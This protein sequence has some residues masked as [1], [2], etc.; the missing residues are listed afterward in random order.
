MALIYNLVIFFYGL[1]VRIAALFN[2][3]AK[4]FVTGRKHWQ[5]KLKDATGE[6]RNPYIWFHCASLGE[7][8]Q[9][10]PVIEAVKK[11]YPAYKIILTFFSPSGYE[12]RK[13]YEGADIVCYLPLDTKKNANTFL[14]IVQPQ[15]AFFVKYEFWYNYISGLKKRHIPLYIISVIFRKE[16]LFFQNTPGGKWYRKILAGVTHFFVQ[17]EK[18][19]ALLNSI[20]IANY[21]I[22][23][24]TRFDRVAEIAR[25]ARSFEMVERFKG[26]DVTL[27]AG[28]TWKPDEELLIDFINKSSGIKFII[29]PHEVKTANIN[30]ICQALEKNFVLFSKAQHE[31]VEN[32]DVLIIDSIGI[33]SSL[34]QY[35]DMAYIGG[36]FG[37]GIHNTL[38]A[39]TFKLPVIFGPNYLKFNEAVELVEQGGAFSVDNQDALNAVLN[40]L[41]GGGDVR[42]K[43]SEACKKYVDKNV[44]AAKLIVEK[45]FSESK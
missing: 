6:E 5:Q 34:Y 37:V 4:F 35:G 39:A 30:R 12:I 25:G 20:G 44:G 38:E 10:R 27:I 42:K 32:V 18:S 9:G 41:V 28:S 19:A 43:A 29:A 23:G 2:D 13:N 22:A 21:S 26:N 1:A 14:D 15:K 24:D 17:N 16:Q 40:R 45:I 8:E 11:Q 3:K 7:F 36:G 31:P 33:L